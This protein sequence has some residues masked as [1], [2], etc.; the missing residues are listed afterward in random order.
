MHN[1][2]EPQ[3]EISY[4]EPRK[5]QHSPSLRLLCFLG[6]ITLAACSNA[7]GTGPAKV[8]WDRDTCERCRMVIS[9]HDFAAQVRGGPKSKLFHFDD[10]GCA[11]LWLEQQPWGGD[12]ATEIWVAEHPGGA[13]LDAKTAFYK[14]VPNSP[15]A[16]KLGAQREAGPN[17]MS[18]TAAR[19][20]IFRFEAQIRAEGSVPPTSLPLLTPAEQAE[21]AK[22]AIQ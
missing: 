12:S 4:A 22:G 8:H 11:V 1:T 9:E 3:G 18:F 6:V 21:R 19:E 20:H 17:T 14:Q 13:W 10:I 2:K 15:M 5:R 7:P 16:Y